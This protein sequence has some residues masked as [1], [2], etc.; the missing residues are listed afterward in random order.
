MLFHA[1][2]MMRSAANRGVDVLALRRALPFRMFLVAIFLFVSTPAIASEQPVPLLNRCHNILLWLKHKKS[3]AARI[4]DEIYVYKFTKWLLKF[5]VESFLS[6]AKL[7]RLIKKRVDR[8]FYQDFN[9][10]DNARSYLKI[11]FSLKRDLAGIANAV[12]SGKK[13]VDLYLFPVEEIIEKIETDGRSIDDIAVDYVPLTVDIL[14]R[15][16]ADMPHQ[17][18]LG[19]RAERAKLDYLNQVLTTRPLLEPIKYDSHKKILAEASKKSNLS[20]VVGYNDYHSAWIEPNGAHFLLPRG[21]VLANRGTGPF[22]PFYKRVHLACLHLDDAIEDQ[23]SVILA[24][25][26][27]IDF[28]KT[29]I[30]LSALREI[31]KHLDFYSNPSFFSF[32]LQAFVPS[33][34][35]QDYAVFFAKANT[36]SICPRDSWNNEKNCWVFG[37]DDLD[38]GI[39]SP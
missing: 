39:H 36:L 4:R 8:L 20:Y 23:Y 32:E 16:I 1:T 18:Q 13:S 14:S 26:R 35:D 37:R 9:S 21:L 31:G 22:K 33:T 29:A 15:V 6:S 11:L 34:V 2:N 17:F 5:E 10:S 38:D 27:V 7:E 3:I 30:N 19:L 24:S 25:D 12:G 28:A